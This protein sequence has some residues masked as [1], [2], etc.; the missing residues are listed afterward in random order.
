MEAHLVPHLVPHLVRRGLHSFALG[1]QLVGVRLRLRLR[2]RPR[3]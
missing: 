2:L 1:A 3:G